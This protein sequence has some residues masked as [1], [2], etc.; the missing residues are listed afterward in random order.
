MGGPVKGHFHQ[1]SDLI[2]PGGVDIQF[3]SHDFSNKFLNFLLQVSRVTF[4]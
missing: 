1:S 2:Q 4:C 3:Q